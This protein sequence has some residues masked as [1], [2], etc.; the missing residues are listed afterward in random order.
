MK[1]ASFPQWIQEIVS[2]SIP[3]QP[4]LFNSNN[5]FS[6][7]SADH[8]A[9]WSAG[10]GDAV[11]GTE[12]NSSRDASLS[13]LSLSGW[14]GRRP[15]RPKEEWRNYQRRHCSR[16]LTLDKRGKGKNGKGEEGGP[17]RIGTNAPFCHSREGRE[18]T[19]DKHEH[20]SD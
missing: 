8:K 12:G 13:P 2:I 11:M 19:D 4:S 7:Y 18:R 20:F 9:M 1:I 16:G 15:H 3:N 10:G 6:Y 14:R 17:E 5:C